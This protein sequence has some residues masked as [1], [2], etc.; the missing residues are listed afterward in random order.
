M[1]VCSI[2]C[3][4][5]FHLFLYSIIFRLKGKCPSHFLYPRF[6]SDL[7]W[8]IQISPAVLYTLYKLHVSE[9]GKIGNFDTR[10]TASCLRYF[11]NT[12]SKSFQILLRASP[13]FTKIRSYE[14]IIIKRI[15]SAWLLYL[16]CSEQMRTFV[17]TETQTKDATSPSQSFSQSVSKTKEGAYKFTEALVPNSVTK[18]LCIC[19]GSRCRLASKT[20]K[21]QA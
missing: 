20:H 1:R 5:D 3:R 9:E 2:L 16:K 11:E 13:H 4:C 10:G 18:K 14:N 15:P 12:R 17:L 6:L 8:C 7:I 21:N 19:L